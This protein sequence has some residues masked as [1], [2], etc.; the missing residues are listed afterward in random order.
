[1]TPTITWLSICSRLIRG[2]QKEGLTASR[3]GT[4]VAGLEGLLVATLAEIISAGMDND[5]AL[6]EEVSK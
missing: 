1:M 6:R 2:K 4:S 3:A 5:G